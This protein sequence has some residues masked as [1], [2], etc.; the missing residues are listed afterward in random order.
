MALALALAPA[1]S[2]A[3][4]GSPLA[5]RLSA[6]VREAGL[7]ER[8]AVAV[9]DAASGR[10][11]FALRADRALNPASNMKLLTA[12]AALRHLGPGYRFRTALYGRIE[13]PGRI[14]TLYLQGTGDPSLRREDLVALAERLADRGVRRVEGIAVDATWFDAQW[15]PPAFEQQPEEAAAFRAAVSA[16]AVDRAAYVLAVQPTAEAG[17]PARVLVHPPAHF[18]MEGSVA[19]VPAGPPKVVV[20]QRLDE[21]GRRTWLRV[22]GEVPAGGPPMRF[23]RRVEQ[24]AHHAGAAL[25]EALRRVGIRVGRRIELQA[26]PPGTPM[27]ASH[28]SAPLAVLLRAM[29]KWSD[30]FVAEMVTKAV[31]ASQGRPG[32]TAGGLRLAA[33]TLRW[34]GADPSTARLR[35]GS[36]L[37]DANRLSARHLVRLLSAMYRNTALR[38]EYLAHLAVGGEDGTLRRRLRDLPAPRIVRAKTGTLADAIALSGYVLGPQPGQAYAFSVLMEGV[39]GRLGA[40]RALADDVARALA[41]A[42][43]SR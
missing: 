28:R 3:Q 6:L 39:R 38:D 37:F 29:G 20:V 17:T 8:V 34:A 2:G 4:Q 26:V 31:G 12:A 43:W 40:A 41:D 15:L 10:E 19:T 33:E 21:D 22:R 42:L 27:L 13:P 36:G 32:T 7:G 9:A 18:A 30:N 35:N 14:Q 24:P 1:P 11:L 16:V 23:R 5:A 25:R